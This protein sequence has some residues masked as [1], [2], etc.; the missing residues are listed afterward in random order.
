MDIGITLTPWPPLPLRRRGGIPRRHSEPVEESP[1]A[2]RRRRFRRFPAITWKLA[3]CFM[4]RLSGGV[5]AHEGRDGGG[6]GQGTIAVGAAEGVA[7]GFALAVS[8]DGVEVEVGE[9]DALA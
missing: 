9:E 6:G 1:G 4:V 7:P 3:L 5:C 2:K 8:A